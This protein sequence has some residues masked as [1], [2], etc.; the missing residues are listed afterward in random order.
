MPDVVI[1]GSVAFDTIEAPAGGAERVLGGAATYASLAASYFAPA[2][3]VGVVGGDF[4]EKPIA[5]LRK[6][7]VDLEGLEIIPDG[8]T[9]FWH[10]RYAPNL[11]DRT[12]LETQLNVFADFR[13]KIPA[14]YQRAPFLLLGNIHPELQL[15]VLEQVKRPRLI[16]CDT[17]N[18][19]IETALEPLRRLLGRIDILCVNDSEARQLSGKVS[20]PAAA[21]WLMA[22]GPRRIIVKRG[23]HGC[24]MYG[25]KGFFSIPACYVPKPVDPTGAGDTFAGGFLGYLAACG[26]INEQT[27]RQALVVGSVM[28]SFCVEGF[29]VERL[30]WLKTGEVAARCRELYRATQF[31]PV[32]FRMPKS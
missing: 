9:F 11:N 29:S 7:G 25:P 4:G 15:N 2:G 1:V 20:M 32:R 8:K 18:L 21:E 22:Q 6:R 3:V 12:T 24:S 23:D 16:L 13:P 10:G 26:L 17:M 14:S 5:L 30:L 28:A 27:L 19:W 31:E